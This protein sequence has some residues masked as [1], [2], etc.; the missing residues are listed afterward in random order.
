[1]SRTSFLT[2]NESFFVSIEGIINPMGSICKGRSISIKILSAGAVSRAP[3]HIMQAFSS[4]TI[5]FNTSGTKATG[6]KTSI[7]SAV[8]EGDVMA[9]VEDFGI[10]NPAAATIGTIIRDTLFPGTPPFNKIY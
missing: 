10:V 6:A 8:P 7:E 3:P 9:L 2:P 5:L 4:D 1:M